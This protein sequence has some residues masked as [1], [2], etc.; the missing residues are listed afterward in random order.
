MAG[1]ISAKE[2]GINSCSG[3]YFG[4]ALNIK[5][6][7]YIYLCVY[8]MAHVEAKRQTAQVNSLSPSCRSWGPNSGHQI[9]RQV[10][11]PTDPSCQSFC[12]VLRAE[13]QIRL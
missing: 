10:P 2:F 5:K 13:V 3:Y 7:I 1:Y 4:L 8:P 6:N 12:L 9:W 11:S